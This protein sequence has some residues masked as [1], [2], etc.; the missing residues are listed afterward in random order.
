MLKSV[1]VKG[2]TLPC[3]IYFYDEIAV[4]IHIHILPRYALFLI[5]YVFGSCYS[6][7]IGILPEILCWL[8]SF[9]GMSLCSF[10]I[11]GYVLNSAVDV[12]VIACP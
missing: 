3:P 5:L 7:D 11:K 10:W 12:F 4:P 1:L 8:E 9:Y 6:Y 2:R